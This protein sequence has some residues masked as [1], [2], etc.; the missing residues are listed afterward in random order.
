M[1]FCAGIEHGVAANLRTKPVGLRHMI[2]VILYSV[3]CICIA[4]DKQL[5][6]SD[7]I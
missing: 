3:Q 4:L 6:E 5:A 2:Y 1:K 7:E